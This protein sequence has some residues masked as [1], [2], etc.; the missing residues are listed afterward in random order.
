MHV[1][2]PEPAYVPGLHPLHGVA[3]FYFF[4]DSDIKKDSNAQATIIS[5]VIDETRRSRCPSEGSYE[6][7]KGQSVLIHIGEKGTRPGGHEQASPRSAI[8]AVIL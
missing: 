7:L 5:Q 6:G 1:V 2:T 8:A 4:G 3:E